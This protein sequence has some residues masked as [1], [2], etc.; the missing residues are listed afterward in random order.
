MMKLFKDIQKIILKAGDDMQSYQHKLFFKDE[1]QLKSQLIDKGMKFIE[2]EK[3][4]FIEKSKNS[5]FLSLNEKQKQ[6]YNE[7]INV[8]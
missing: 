6:I 8:K 3:N 4:A 1:D 7:I 5:I 2:V